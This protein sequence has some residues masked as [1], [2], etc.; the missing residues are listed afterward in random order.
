MH[1][2]EPW[3]TYIDD[4]DGCCRV[5][6]EILDL[7]VVYDPNDA[8]RIVASVNT[9]AGIPIDVLE[10]D[11]PTFAKYLTA[12]MQQRDELLRALIGVVI[13]CEGSG[14]IGQDGQ[15]LKTVREAIEK[16]GAGTTAKE[17]T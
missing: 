14:Y 7:G 15:Y 2:K 12:L 8:H 16:V 10:F 6:T 1:T 13:R 4:A 11:T 3:K 17:P 9:C 5:A